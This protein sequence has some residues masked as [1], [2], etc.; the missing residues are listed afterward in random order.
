MERCL[1]V[2]VGQ[3]SD[4]GIKDLNQD[5]HG[6]AIPQEPQLSSKGIVI[7]LADG[8]SSSTVSQIASAAAING[9]LSDYY[10]TSETWSVKQSAQRVLYATNSWL[11]SQTRQSQYRYDKD[12]AMSAPLAH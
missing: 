5:F 12:K 10:C 9:F 11:H 8:I 1:K 2:T 4:K 6:V 3:C 7:A